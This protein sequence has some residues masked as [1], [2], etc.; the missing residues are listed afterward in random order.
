MEK[1]LA[2]SGILLGIISFFV[3]Q[4]FFLSS[5]ESLN[6]ITY[7]DYGEEVCIQRGAGR[8]SWESCSEGSLTDIALFFTILSGVLA[9]GL[10]DIIGSRTFPP[11][12]KYSLGK[13]KYFIVLICSSFICMT[14]LF[15]LL[16][17]GAHAGNWI[18]LILAIVVTYFGYGYMEKLKHDK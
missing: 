8:S 1:F 7:I 4:N 17:F 16:I 14:S 11:F 12:S 9:A 3:F 2:W 10:F 5:I 6:I 13:Q 18:N 15:V